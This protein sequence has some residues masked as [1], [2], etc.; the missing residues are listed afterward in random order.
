MDDA[1]SFRISMRSTMMFGS[2][3]RSVAPTAPREPDGA[4]RRPFISNR[5]RVAPKPRSERVFTPPPPL[6]T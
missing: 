4:T 6:T 5:V 3:F 2:T 1:P